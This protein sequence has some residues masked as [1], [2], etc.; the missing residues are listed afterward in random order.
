MS[1]RNE[2]DFNVK[3]VL[4][5]L[6]RI[7]EAHPFFFIQNFQ[8]SQRKCKNT[9]LNASCLQALR[10]TSSLRL[11]PWPSFF[12]PTLFLI[13]SPTERKDAVVLG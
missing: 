7:L 9:E 6:S 1:E 4:I 13:H 11:Q 3:E 2:T 10:I 12:F 8:F 5:Q